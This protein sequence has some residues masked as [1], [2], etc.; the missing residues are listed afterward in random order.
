MQ[1]LVVEDEPR[2]AKVLQQGLTEEGHQAI[3]THNGRDGL[4]LARASRFDVIVLDIMLPGL[5]GFEVAR[6]LRAEK[7][8]TPILVLTARDSNEDVVRGLNVGADDYLT[9]PFPWKCFWPACA[10][11]RAAAPFQPRFAIRSAT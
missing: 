1:I 10:R 9:K 7:N 11:Y 4:A 6:R 8:R 5:D 2:M 3:L